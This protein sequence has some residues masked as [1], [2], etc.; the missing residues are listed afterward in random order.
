MKK[1]VT[2]YSILLL[3]LLSSGCAILDG[4]SDKVEEWLIVHSAPEA[5]LTINATVIMSLASGNILAFTDNPERNL[6]YITGE[7]FTLRWTNKVS[8]NADPPNALLTWVEDGA[9]NEA[10]VV[11]TD[12][13]SDGNTITY[14]IEGMGMPD[15][16]ISLNMV[17]MYI[18]K[19]RAINS[20][21]E[22]QIL[23]FSDKGCPTNCPKDN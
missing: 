7:E 19:E 23:K 4:K 16:Q 12:A 21:Q 2:T 11:I 13:S 17:S 9:L 18:F 10:I 20:P 14:S 1:L 15:S 5:Q 8:F 22:P 6:A 3:A